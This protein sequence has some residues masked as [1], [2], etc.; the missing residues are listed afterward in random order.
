MRCAVFALRHQSDSRKMNQIIWSGDMS[1]Q[2]KESSLS[3]G[4]CSSFLCGCKSQ[5]STF[6]TP[7]K[8]EEND[9][10]ESIKVLMG[11]GPLDLEVD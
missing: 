7:L 6:S 8:Q 5:I 3:H 1:S 2:E 10:L 4:P 9:P 11:Q